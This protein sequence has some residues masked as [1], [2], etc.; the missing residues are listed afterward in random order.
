M[1]TTLKHTKCYSYM[2]RQY[3]KLGYADEVTEV[4]MEVDVCSQEV[5]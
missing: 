2:I 4:N 5:T 1:V 3:W